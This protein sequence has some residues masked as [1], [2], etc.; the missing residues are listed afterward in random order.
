[1]RPQ[2]QGR[3]Q[4]VWSPIRAGT[5]GAFSC[6]PCLDLVHLVTN[7]AEARDIVVVFVRV[8][9]PIKFAAAEEG[10]VWPSQQSWTRLD[11]IWK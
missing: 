10:S 3:G 8:G 1:V 7:A 9:E 4:R 2:G 11:V 5:V 6:V